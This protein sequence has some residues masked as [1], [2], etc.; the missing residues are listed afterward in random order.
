MPDDRPQPQ[1]LGDFEILG[2]LGRGGM[3]VVYA[4]RQ[5]SL[6]RPVAVKVLSRMSGLSTTSIERF[7][8]EAQA[9]AR[10]QHTNIVPIHTSGESDGVYF[11]AM[12]LVE[13]PSLDRVIE[14]LGDASTFEAA[15]RLARPLVN[16][17]GSTC[18]AT[19]TDTR[20][21]AERRGETPVK[22]PGKGRPPTDRAYFDTVARVIAEVAE[23]LAF[24]HEHGVVHRDIKPSNLLVGTDGQ[25]NITDF[26]LARG[27]DEATLT[28]SG[29]L[30]GS[31]VYMSP[32][33][34]RSERGE[35]D[36]RT[37][38]YSLGATFFELLTL[39]RLFPG[40]SIEEI[41]GRILIDEPRSPRRVHPAVPLDLD[42]ICLKAV[43][44][45]MDRRYQSA[46]EMAED[47]RSWLD[48]RP[49]RARRVG[50]VGRAVKWTRRRPTLAALIVTLVVAV[51]V[52]SFL[53][54][55]LVRSEQ[56]LVQFIRELENGGRE[57]YRKRGEIAAACE[58]RA[59]MAIADIGA[60]TGLFTRLFASKVGPAGK[61]FAVDIEAS[62]VTHIEQVW[63]DMK[64]RDEN[65]GHVEGVLC[66]DR[67]V[68]LEEAS[69]DLAFVCDTYAYF[70]HPRDTMASLWSALRPGGEL[71]IVHV[72][73]EGVAAAR[74]VSAE[75]S[76]MGFEPV[77][78]DAAPKQPDL[79]SGR[80]QRFRK[81]P[82]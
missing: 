60:G 32:E 39:E 3:G 70:K 63:R 82:V 20:K 7:H 11:Y 45:D 23:A 27:A 35:V 76:A 1:I 55:R 72:A 21:L 52:T 73:E 65:I 34:L 66:D 24:A 12:E 18:D 44:H 42:T 33:Q 13:G 51:G 61:V 67:S 64:S 29:E 50:P 22:V 6:G 71:V 77:P 25:L 16:A 48:H 59:G 28:G 5:T 9:A 36:H 38:I 30:L 69:I 10:L 56:E 26:G 49:I 47:L 2:E 58:I 57:V 81:A 41:I 68:G 15:V 75:I 4:A 17:Y 31:P 79:Q 8:R 80:F 54:A 14:S 46:G 78:N 19:M 62:C 43:A 37:D 40:K 74:D 53:I